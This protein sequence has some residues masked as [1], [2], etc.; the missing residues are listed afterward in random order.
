MG[1]TS[2]PA[3]SIASA[4][5]TT[6]CTTT[7]G[8]SS[9][10][11]A[12]VF[13]AVGLSCENCSRMNIVDDIQRCVL[14]NLPGFHGDVRDVEAW[15]TRDPKRTK[16]R[17]VETSGDSSQRACQRSVRRLLFCRSISASRTGSLHPHK[18]PTCSAD[19][20]IEIRCFNPLDLVPT[21]TKGLFERVN[22][23]RKDTPGPQKDRMQHHAF[24]LLEVTSGAVSD[25]LR[26]GI[27]SGFS[28][29]SVNLGS[30]LSHSSCAKPVASEW[31]S[32]RA[33][34]ISVRWRAER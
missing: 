5:C 34:C 24:A 27:L 16:L 3:F 33:R 14:L 21:A 11:L 29:E 32:G 28:I 1:R 2:F 8:H 26:V 17:C 31:F 10:F 23:I 13:P 19:H 15:K 25:S 6:H 4:L 7:C 18:V 20:H 12:I 9:G 22:T 30:S